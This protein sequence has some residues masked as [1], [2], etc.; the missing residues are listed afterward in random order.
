[1]SRA[2][3]FRNPEGLYFISFATVGWIDVFTRRIYK[4]IHRMKTILMAFYILININAVA[5]SYFPP[6]KFDT[7]NKYDSLKLK[8]GYWLQLL[9]KD[10]IPTTD[11][12]EAVFYKYT[13]YNGV[14]YFGRNIALSIFPDDIGLRESKL[15][16]KG[17][18]IVKT[19]SSCI[20]KKDTVCIL[21]GVYSYYRKGKLYKEAKY[22]DGMLIYFKSFIGNGI[23]RDYWNY[24]DR[25]Q[26]L[27][28]SYT[29]ISY[30]SKGQ[31]T[32]KIQKY[33]LNNIWYSKSLIEDGKIS[34]KVY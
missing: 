31:I 28:L 12:K 26:N 4:E 6:V 17:I 10:A 2:Y 9:N 23:L 21:N 16:R 19:D 11:I 29:V 20:R 27:P 8:T 15:I 5:Q 7:L 22:I 3:K 33:K 25:V 1:M 34:N 14:R 24:E 30:N 13:Y 32:E 18:I